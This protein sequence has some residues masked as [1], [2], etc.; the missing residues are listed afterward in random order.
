MLQLYKFLAR[1][2]LS[3]AWWSMCWT[4]V[5]KLTASQWNL[6]LSKWFGIVSLKQ[7]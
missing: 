7:A 2:R 6:L 1:A 4:S 3:V 5:T